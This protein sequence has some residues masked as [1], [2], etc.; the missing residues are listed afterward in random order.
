MHKSCSPAENIGKQLRTSEHVKSSDIILRTTKDS[1]EII[2]FSLKRISTVGKNRRITVRK[3]S[4]N[5]GKHLKSSDIIPR[6][7]EDPS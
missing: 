3:Q 4:K 6:T 2:K 7:T 5:I 1:S